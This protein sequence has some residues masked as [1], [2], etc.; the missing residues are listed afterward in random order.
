[1]FS[2]GYISYDRNTILAGRSR[3]NPGPS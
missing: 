1:M 3:E 2:I